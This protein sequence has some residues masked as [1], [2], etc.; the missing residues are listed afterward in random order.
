MAVS[1][2]YL[3]KPLAYLQMTAG[4][5]T[6]PTRTQSG[7]I[8]LSASGG[9]YPKACILQSPLNPYEYFVV[10]MR[11]K[12]DPSDEGTLD[13]RIGGTG[14]IVYRVD[15]TVDGMSN[16]FGRTG[17]YVFQ[18]QPGQ[19]GYHVNETLCLRQAY[20]SDTQGRTSIGRA[21]WDCGLSDGA[22]TF[23]DGSNS[24]LVIHNVTTLSDGVMQ[25]QVD[26]PD[27]SSLDLW[28]DTTVPQAQHAAL[29]DI[30]G[31]CY[32]ALANGRT[33]QLYRYENH[34][35][36]P[37]GTALQA[38]Q[39][40]GAVALTHQDGAPVVAY[41]DMD[42]T[43]T[44]QVLR[45]TSWQKAGSLSNVSDLSIQ[46]AAG[47]VVV[48]YVTDSTCAYVTALQNGTLQEPVQWYSGL[49]GT[50]RVA[51]VDG[52][53][54]LAV[55]EAT[56][57]SLVIR[58]WQP[59]GTVEPV[60]S[61]SSAAV[62]S[63]DLI[64]YA[65]TLY[66][67]ISDGTDHLTLSAYRDGSWQTV[68]TQT[69]DS[70]SPR[71]AVAQGNL[72]VLSA[73]SR[74]SATDGL[75]VFAVEDGTFRQEG[76]S[77]VENKSA[78]SFQLAGSGD[79]LFVSYEK[80]GVASIRQKTVSNRLLSLTLEGP[81]TKSYR[82]GDDVSLAGLVV[83]AN[84]QNGTT[85]VL[86]PGEYTVTSFSTQ[87]VGTHLAQVNFG[88]VSNSFVYEVFADTPAPERQPVVFRDPSGTYGAQ[89]VPLGDDNRVTAP[90]WKRTG[91]TL[92]WSR[93]LTGLQ[94]GEVITAVWTPVPP[95]TPKLTG[96]KSTGYQ[97]IQ[98]SWQP[99][100]GATG[101]RVY[102]KTVG[103]SWKTVA[104][105][106]GGSTKTYGDK[107]ATCGTAYTYTVR[108]YR[109]QDGTNVWSG[110]DKTGLKAM[111]V[112][113][114]PKLTG[115][116][117]TGYQSI[118]LSWQPVTGATGYRVYR[119][120]S[121]GSW[122]TVATLPGS[123][124]KTY[125]DKT[126]TCGTAYIYTV[127]AYRTQNGTNVWS[128][129]DKTGLK[130]TAVPAAPTVRAT[131]SG[132]SARLSWQAVPGA[133][134]YVVYVRSGSSWKRVSSVKGTSYT[135]SGFIKGR[136]YTYTVRAYRTVKGKNVYGAYHAAGTK[137]TI[138]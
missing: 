29:A 13:T 24:G 109:T 75:K 22:L 134:G 35:W 45:G 71:L 52:R 119:K 104:T 111:A 42:M 3:T 9:T 17:I 6:L 108:A 138:R 32:A 73:P 25:L 57:Q 66:A 41:T 97:S 78:L 120:T 81:F 38:A 84:Y 8:T 61:P 72:Y 79:Q 124:T 44:V 10:E 89:T 19:D 103:G 18:P 90:A 110:Y 133:S 20:L 4:W 118:Q 2:R 95:A 5:I 91:Y 59:G 132:K 125:V 128:S 74:V 135:Q 105:L 36:Q 48:G 76:S 131:S 85:R 12:G 80:D 30:G 94:G 33:V 115:I 1:S 114:T 69:M 130:A 43:A 65:H 39:P 28:Q 126:A 106:S 56:N 129:Y 40:V 116:K 77:F 117:S 93:A 49:C 99:V 15:T 127:R 31:V 122:K 53:V 7:T 113:A 16:Y 21:E 87:T 83:T 14:V 55:R 27:A 26:F 121:G 136:T 51:G 58:S 67:L 82:V 37:V 112:P 60:A 64:A 23:S 88:G 68:G 63:A 46:P 86:E 96:I 123:S 102:R 98:L 70:F 62:K 101:Y 92:T 34:A 50:P 11:Q 47:T 100:T 54:Y 137:V 107:T